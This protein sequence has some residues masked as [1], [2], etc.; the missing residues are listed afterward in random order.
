MHPGMLTICSTC[1]RV[2]QCLGLRPP[3]QAK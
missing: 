2:E 1:K 3:R